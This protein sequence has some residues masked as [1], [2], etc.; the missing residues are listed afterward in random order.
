MS[1]PVPT[2]LVPEVEECERYGFDDDVDRRIRLYA[3][4]LVAGAVPARWDRDVG[5]AIDDGWL[6]PS[7]DVLRYDDDNG[8]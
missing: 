3:D 6:S 4:L 8:W 5:K 1:Q 2:H 7:G